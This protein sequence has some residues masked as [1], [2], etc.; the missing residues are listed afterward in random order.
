M[1]FLLNKRGLMEQAYVV[2]SL[3]RLS[4]VTNRC[5]MAAARE[6]HLVRENSMH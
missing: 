6:T 2:G 4:L 5:C 1:K 3:C